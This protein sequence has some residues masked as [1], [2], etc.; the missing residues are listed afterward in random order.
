MTD[1]QR[2]VAQVDDFCIKLLDVQHPGIS[3]RTQIAGLSTALGVKS[4][5]IQRHRISA[6]GGFAAGDVCIEL[7]QMGVL[8]KNL[9]R[10]HTV[11]L[12]DNN[13]LPNFYP[14]F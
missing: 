12:W 4:S 11:L 1:G 5:G 2:G 7:L 9:S 13:F 6:F 8:V 10:L 14:V 3:Q